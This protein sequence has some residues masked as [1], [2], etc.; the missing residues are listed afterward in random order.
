M[1]N[2]PLTLWRLIVT[3]TFRPPYQALRH[4]T[5]SKEENA[6]AGEDW[7]HEFSHNYDAVCMSVGACWEYNT[8]FNLCA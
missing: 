5:L 1:Q 2:I 4:W 6:L 8:Y 7:A 3:F